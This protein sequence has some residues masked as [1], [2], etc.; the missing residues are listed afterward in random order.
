MTSNPP[1]LP[2]PFPEKPG[3]TANL[4]GRK[5]G[6]LLVV[7]FAGILASNRR[8]NWNCRCECGTEISVQAKKLTSRHTLSCGCLMREK[9]AERFYKHGRTTSPEF[10]S[11]SSALGRCTNPKN[12]SYKNYG[13]R[14]ITMCARWRDSFENF[15]TDMGARPSPSHSLD[16][17]SNEGNY[18]KENCRWATKKTQSNNRR[19]NKIISKDGKTLSI[20]QWAEELGMKEFTLRARL[21]SGW[22]L[23]DAF[24]RKV[25]VHPSQRCDSVTEFQQLLTT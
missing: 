23:D 9:A 20:T 16:R 14:G 8:I 15:L 12:K 18:E 4:S 3:K 22:A 1:A 2:V 13:G 6:R 19:T 21:N 10:N 25:R 24:E 17:I 7:S 5:F 11:W